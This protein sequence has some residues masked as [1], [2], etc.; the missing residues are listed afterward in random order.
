MNI[1]RN[2]MYFFKQ[3]TR[4]NIGTGFNYFQIEIKGLFST[5]HFLF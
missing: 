1:L 5:F 3:K 2:A 4:P